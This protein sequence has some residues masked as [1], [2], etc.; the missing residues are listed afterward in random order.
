MSRRSGSLMTWVQAIVAYVIIWWVVVF[1]VL[2]FGVRPAE[3]GDLGH[4]VGA[5]ANPR[6]GIKALITTAIA[7]VLWLALYLVTGSDL[8]SF[9]QP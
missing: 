7:A 9:R 1:A 5:P 4:S 3:E 6:L 2:P 8:I